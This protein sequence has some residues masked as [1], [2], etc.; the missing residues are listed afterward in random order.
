MVEE[1]Y[2]WSDNALE[3]EWF[4]SLDP[5]LNESRVQ[6]IQKRGSNIQVIE[7]LVAYDRPDII[8]LDKEGNP[9]LV[10]EK[11][12]EVPTGHN[13][14]QRVARLVRA[15]EFGLPTFFFL[16]FDARKHGTFSSMCTINVRLL[17]AMLRIGEVHKCDVLPVNWPCDADGELIVDGS[18]NLRLS[19]LIGSVLDSRIGKAND[20]L[21]VYEQ[22]V[23]LELE[24]RENA[25]PPYRGLPKSVL[26]EGTSSFFSRIGIPVEEN[27]KSLLK[28]KESLIYVMNMTPD[29]CKRQDP[30]TGMQFIYDYTWLRKGPSPRSRQ[31]NLIL[32]FPLVDKKTWIKKNPEDYKSKSCNWYLTADAIVLCDGIIYIENW[33]LHHDS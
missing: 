15:A 19:A 22:E 23:L 5:R 9:V 17:R 4:A 10:L 11:T 31:K 24:F 20:V 14:G 29:K 18:E 2:I 26:V 30:Y 32:H 7:D 28:R 12:R 13:V 8:L 27:A 25:Y 33:P 1:F 3:A 16:P 21:E 6:I